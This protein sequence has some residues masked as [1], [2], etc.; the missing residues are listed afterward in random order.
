MVTSQWSTWRLK[1]TGDS[2]FI[3]VLRRTSNPALLAFFRLIPLTKGRSSFQFDDVIIVFHS[4]VFRKFYDILINQLSCVSA[5]SSTNLALGRPTWQSSTHA[6]YI[7]PDS[8]RAV[9][10]NRDPSYLHGSCM[11]T[12]GNLSHY[13]EFLAR[14]AVIHLVCQNLWYAQ[15]I[16]KL[17]K[18][19]KNWPNFKENYSQCAL[20]EIF[21]QDS[22]SHRYE[23]VYINKWRSHQAHIKVK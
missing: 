15:T 6:H 19:L 14:D 1:I 18:P 5:S 2:R 11:H 12:A 17:Q 22:I 16:F 8:S 20:Y 7:H 23:K 21:L 9:D 13:W 3:R 10:G 4:Y